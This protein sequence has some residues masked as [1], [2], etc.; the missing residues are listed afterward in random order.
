MLGAAGGLGRRLSLRKVAGADGFNAA[1]YG[2]LA[3]AKGG[4]NG[5][6]G[7]PVG[8]CSD[9][10]AVGAVDGCGLDSGAGD[11]CIFG[12][13][14]GG[15]G[16]AWQVVKRRLRVVV[17]VCVGGAGEL[18]AVGRVAVFGAGDDVRGLS[19]GGV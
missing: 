6:D 9:D 1:L 15:G 13:A 3:G 2:A 11:G 10:C 18:A 19:A 5:A 8:K 4:G 17:A 7:V 14:D 12:A 16:D